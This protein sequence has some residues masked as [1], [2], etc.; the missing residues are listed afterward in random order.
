MST[1]TSL[2]RLGLNAFL[3]CILFATITTQA[4]ATP[5]D[6]A[7]PMVGTAGHGHTF[8]GPTMPFGAVQH[9]P[10][11][12]TGTWDGCSGY[13]YSDS[14]IL[15]FTHTHLSGTGAG[16][17]GDILIMPEVGP[18]KFTDY[19]SHFSHTNEVAHP[20]Y[21]KVYLDDPRVTA[22]LTTTERT[23]FHRYTFPST[24][25]AHFVIDLDHGIQSSTTGGKINIE[26]DTTISGTREANGWGGGRAVYFVIQFSRPFKDWQLQADG[27]FAV[28]R[29]TNATGRAV[30][31]VVDYSTTDGE[32]ILVKVG[33]SATGI[34]GARKNLETENAGWDFDA[35][36]AAAAKSWNEALG[37]IDID[38]KDPHVKR[39]FYSNLYL[40]MIAPALF[41]DVDKSHFGFDHKVH[42]A[43]F[44]Q[45]TTF[46]LWDTYRAEHPLLNLI[47]PQRV[48][49]M[50]QSILAQKQELGW[51]TTAIWPLWANET[52]CMIGYHSADVIADA[53]LKGLAGNNNSLPFREGAGV[54]SE[55]AYNAIRDTALQSDGDLGNYGKLGYVPSKS[56]NQS[57]SKTIE[58]SV[59]DWC[60]AK[61]AEALGHKEDA[62]RFYRRSL[63]YYNLFDRKVG[64]E[65]GRKA[66]GNW[67]APFDPIG[68]V[69]DEYTEA[70]AWQ[71]A[72]GAQQDVPGMIRLYGGDAGFVRKLDAMFASDSKVNSDQ[73]DISGL[74]GQYSQG[75]EQCH[76][77]AY[78]YDYAGAPWKTQYWTR[79]VMAREFADTVDGEC[80]NVDCGQMSAWYIFSALGFYPV[81]PASNVYPIGSP[82]VDKA[83]LRLDKKIYRGRT[84]TLVAV[85]NAPKNVFIQSATWNGKPFD[86]TYLTFKQI[87][88]GG[89]LK[90]MM[91][92]KPNPHWAS[93]TSS[94]PPSTIPSTIKYPALP[95]PAVDKYIA[96][97]LPIR[98]ACGSDDPIGNFVPDPNMIQGSING[99][100]VNINTEDVDNAAPIGVYQNERWGNDFTYSF[101][102]P[103]GKYTVR[104]HFAEIFDN[105]PGDRIEN[106]TVNGQ[107]VLTNFEIYKAAGGVNKAYVKTIDNV[108]AAKGKVDVRVWS[109]KTSPDQHAKINGI[110]ILPG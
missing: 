50:I 101:P 82:V 49:D 94:R 96:L 21:Y 84:F 109:T 73:P 98:D 99:D 45:Y 67:R 27:Q 89:V 31:A 91:G 44:H 83:V 71:Y 59:D 75:D 13:H 66:N 54:G 108:D 33:I 58:Y 62:A 10:D 14:T 104:L 16:S 90:L 85:N 25:Q 15:G 102:V 8:P 23:G 34:D 12:R 77:V 42:A 36:R 60:V 74:I 35:V 56:G 92:P 51:H 9:N 5:V 64:F 47:Q 79:Q 2:K 110:E 41:D 68:L 1:I 95:A 17:L 86:K 87:I 81:N 46:S 70:D 43:D 103:K 26:S 65:R 57:A 63:D 24:D 61:M 22:E 32:P 69:G 28:A 78:L 105:A 37:A 55:A 6:Y 48:P 38:S 39:T 3:P 30:K 18:A 4:L 76:H 29:A 72:F 107:P 40:T 80:G 106:V 100:R 88:G 53:Y 52:W 7:D 93:S 20:G 11:T 19:A 97:H